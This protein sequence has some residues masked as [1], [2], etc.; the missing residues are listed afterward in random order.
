MTTIRMQRLR[1][2]LCSVES[3]FARIASTQAA[4]FS[5]LDRR[6][7]ELV[8]STIF[9]WI[10]RCPEC[11]YCAPDVTKARPEAAAVISTGEYKG[12]LDDPI[13]PELANSFLCQALIESACGDYAEATW[14]LIHAAWV[15]DDSRVPDQAK[16]CRQRAADM[17]GDAKEHGQRIFSDSEESSMAL[18]VD[19]LRRAGEFDVARETI[20][21]KRDTITEDSITR[22]LDFQAVLID[23]KDIFCHSMAEVFAEEKR[24]EGDRMPAPEYYQRPSL[25]VD[26]VIVAPVAGQHKVLLI[27]RK[28]PPFEGRWAIPGGFVDPH[29]PLEEAARRELLEETGVEP[30][31]LEQLHVFGDPG[32]DPRG[33]TISVAYLTVLEEAAARSIQPRAGDDAAD[34]GWFD[35][36]A[37]PPLAFDHAEILAHAR[38]ALAIG[39]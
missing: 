22:I 8:R 26:I 20:A 33:W 7:P 19:L 36:L 15:C 23:K 14:A 38:Q 34:V 29:E 17:L 16:V 1:C 37:P 24:G 25:T 4:G 28:K 35:L 5:D 21:A 2:G 3:E 31:R 10:Q 39:D 27:R 18:L 12:Q 6:P 9:A 32:R 11:G 30:A 13:Y